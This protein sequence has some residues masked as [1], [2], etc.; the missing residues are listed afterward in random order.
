MSDI[1]EKERRGKRFMQKQRHIKRQV[2]IYDTMLGYSRKWIEDNLTEFAGR[3][4]GQSEHRYH[5]KNALNCGDPKCIQCMNP[6]KA[7]GQK[8][9]QERRH[10]ECAETE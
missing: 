3:D 8:T 5:K 2:N 7:F 10:F 1:K 9:M 4:P 6:R